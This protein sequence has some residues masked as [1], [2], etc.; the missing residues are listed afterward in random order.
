M[1]KTIGIDLGTTNSCVSVKEGDNVTVIPNPEGQRTTPSVVAFTKD[2]EI[3]V[4]QLA[5][6][7]AIVN[8]DRTVISIKRSMGSDKTIS[9]DGKSYTPQQISAMILQKLKKDA[10][11]YLGTTVTDAVITCPAYF[12]DAQRQATKDAGTIAGLNVKRIIN[13]PTA[14]C[15]A[16]G[17][18]MEKGDHKIMVYDLGGGTFDVSILDVGEGVFE[19]LSTAGDNLLGGDD[20]DNEIVKWLASEFKKSDGIDLLKDKMA[21]QRLREAAEKAKIE[22]SSM[23]ETTISL[24]FITADANGPKHLELKLTRA[25]FEDLTHALLEKTIAPVKTAMKDAGLAPADINKILLVGGSTR[26]PMVQKL[27]QEIMGKEPTKGINP[28]ECVAMGAALQGAILSGEQQ[29]IVLVDVTP[30]SLGLETLGGVFTK[31]ID[32]NTAIPVSKSQVFTTAADN[33]PQVE[34]HVLQ[35]ERAMAGDNVTLGRFILDGIKPAPRGIPQI[36]VTFDIDANGIVNVTAKDKATGKEQHITIQSSRLTEEEIEKMRRDAEVNESA[37]KKRKELIEARNE[38]ESVIYQSEKLV[39]ESGG[40][41]PAAQARVNEQ[42]AKLREKMGG[43]D[44][45]AIK[46]ETKKLM[47]VMN[48]LAQAAQKAGAGTQPGAGAQPQPPQDNG[49]DGETV[50]AEF[51]EEDN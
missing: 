37:D 42:I 31:I 8:P 32:K 36:E 38:A 18:N 40:A 26:M 19:V 51:H 24:P 20:W 43:E 33:Q 4:G 10:E 35:G 49:G 14:A 9:I 47:D 17:V 29:G 25:K 41:D 46:E 3:L 28:D 34:I 13:E 2:N 45:S 15:L 50:D 39:K 30:L 1:S 23:Q 5:K 48:V 12:T 16:Y 11:E 21:S 22:L 44:S 27:V 6:R 7:Q